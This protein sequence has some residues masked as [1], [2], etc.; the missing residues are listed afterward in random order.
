MKRSV[1]AHPACSIAVARRPAPCFHLY[2]NSSSSHAASYVCMA[3]Y[4]LETQRSTIEGRDPRVRR[5]PGRDAWYCPAGNDCQ[6]FHRH[7]G[8]LGK[9]GAGPPP[10]TC[11]YKSAH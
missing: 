5:P 6:S 11:S 8:L 10:H 1:P 4:G 3:A 9:A 7:V 2:C